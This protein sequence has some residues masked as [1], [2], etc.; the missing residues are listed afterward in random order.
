MRRCLL[1]DVLGGAVDP[2]AQRQ[3]WRRVYT[4]KECRSG[5]RLEV[6]CEVELLMDGL[7]APVVCHELARVLSPTQASALE[8]TIKVSV[9]GKSEWE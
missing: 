8:V 4:L 6:D 5:L 7:G 1:L 3:R 2:D 9:K